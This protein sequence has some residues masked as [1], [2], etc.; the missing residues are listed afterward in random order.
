M[1][2]PTRY[3]RPEVPS[4]VLPP[5]QRV[6]ARA[7][8]FSLAPPLDTQIQAKNRICARSVRKGARESAPEREKTDLWGAKGA[9]RNPNGTKMEA[10]W[11]KKC[12]KIE[13][14]KKNAENPFP[15]ILLR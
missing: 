11:S 14:S 2:K 4:A 1:L 3:H 6:R 7:A 9:E 10:N 15:N 5:H 8:D 13:V 12:A